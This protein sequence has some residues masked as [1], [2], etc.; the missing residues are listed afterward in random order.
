MTRMRPTTTSRRRLTAVLSTAAQPGLRGL[1]SPPPPPPGR[2]APGRPLCPTGQGRR[3][4]RRDAEGLVPGRPHHRGHRR[5]RSHQRQRL[6]RAPRR[7][8]HQPLRGP[9]HPGRRLLPGHLDHQ[10]EQRLEP[11]R[12]VRDPLPRQLERRPRH[13]RCAGRT[14]AVRERLHHRRLGAE[15]GLRLRLHR[16]GQHRGEVLQ[17]RLGPGR[18]DPRVAR[19]G[20]PLTRA[21]SGVAL[22][23]VRPAAPAHLHGGDL[24]RRLPHPVAA[25]EQPGGLRRGLDWEGTLFRAEGRTC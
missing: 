2:Q 19:A 18:V 21:A 3:S 13:H 17:G 8:H 7:G 15:Q 23:G 22:G 16:Q 5:L 1:R 25:R 24:Q 4:R 9:G 14:G 20:H 6:G 12:A 10:H 11:R